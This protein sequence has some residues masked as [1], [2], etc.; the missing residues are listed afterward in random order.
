MTA[1][2]IRFEGHEL[3]VDAET[4]ALVNVGSPDL[5]PLASLPRLRELRLTHTN[6]HRSPGGLPVELDPLASIE[7]LEVLVLPHLPLRDL[8]PLRGL[9]RLR[10]LDLAFTPIDTVE[11]L[12]GLHALRQ[13]RLRATR[14]HDLE[15]LRG[16]ERLAQLDVAHTPVADVEPLS[17][18]AALRELHLEGTRVREDQAAALEAALPDLT[19]VW[20]EL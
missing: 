12:V 13:L 18:L 7:T 20:S 4:V 16:L 11:D 9:V 6:P 17:S 10:L 8:S 1:A 5:T 15:P 14:V 2:T 3:P 19:I